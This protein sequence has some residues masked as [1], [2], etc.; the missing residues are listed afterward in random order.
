MWICRQFQFDVVITQCMDI[1]RLLHLTRLMDIKLIQKPINGFYGNW[2]GN[3]SN[4]GSITGFKHT[5]ELNHSIFFLYIRN[6]TYT[7]FKQMM[8]F[9]VVLCV[10][11][12]VCQWWQLTVLNVWL[13]FVLVWT[14]TF[15]LKLFHLFLCRSVLSI[16]GFFFLL[17][18]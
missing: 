10:Y 5:L 13:D 11:V 3:S 2:N 12:W 6:V 14:F 7:L 17:V 16:F 4:Q 15:C 1:R 8:G 18:V 9:V